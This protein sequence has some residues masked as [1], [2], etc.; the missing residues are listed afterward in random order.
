MSLSK[1]KLRK[2]NKILFYFNITEYNDNDTFIIN[3][4]H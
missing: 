1:I 3:R 4:F 2:R